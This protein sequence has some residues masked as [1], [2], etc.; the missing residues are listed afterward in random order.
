M[1]PLSYEQIADQF[2]CSNYLVDKSGQLKAQ[3]SVW[4]DSEH[5]SPAQRMKLDVSKVEHF[6]FLTFRLKTIILKTLIME[7]LP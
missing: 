5:S 2:G 7:Q 4:G 1:V 6:F 3:N